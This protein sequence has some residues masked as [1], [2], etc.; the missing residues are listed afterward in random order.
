VQWY[1]KE[2]PGIGLLIVSCDN[3]AASPLRKSNHC[4]R[5]CNPDL[6]RACWLTASD[7]MS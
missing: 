5:C 7:S 2:L 6:R 3:V 1:Q 4:R